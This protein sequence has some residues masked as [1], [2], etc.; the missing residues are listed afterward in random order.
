MIRS[1]LIANRGEIAVRIIFAAKELN[2]RTVLAH[3]SADTDSLAFRLADETVCIGPKETK[4]SYLNIGNIISAALCSG[5]DA[6]H[7]GVGFLSENGSFASAVIA[8]GLIFVG[9][10]PDTIT[11]L[12]DKISSRKAA[13]EADVP[14]TPGTENKIGSIEDALKNAS[15]IGYPVILKA[16]AGGGGRGM[17]IVKCPEE[18]ENAVQISRQEALSFF[19]NDSLHMEKYLDHPRHVEIQ[20]IGDGEGNAFHLGE[21]DCSIQCRHQKLME[22]SPSPGITDEMRQSMGEDAVRLFRHLKYKGAGTVEFLVQD[23]RY[24]FMEVNARVQVE[25]PVS[26]MVNFVD[27]IKEQL[28]IASNEKMTIT[29]S[30]DSI[31]SHAIECRI[32]AKNAGKITSVYLPAGAWVRIDTHI[33]EG[34]TVSPFYDPLLAKIIVH[35]PDRQTSIDVMIRVLSLLII[36]GIETDADQQLQIISS[37][38]FRSGNFS[39]ALY[40][41]LFSERGSL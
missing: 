35:T 5:C 29:R 16:S 9:P 31:R 33:Y 11:L 14:V 20:L 23:G 38:E 34:Y 25:H 27:I 40:D 32:N 41:R 30:L 1:L 39:T 12:G 22:E 36:E 3:S 13:A 4:D 18:L 19:G 6:V 26:E 21:R 17:R 7:P 28:L 24:Y 10:S 2:I 15:S 37:K 8:A